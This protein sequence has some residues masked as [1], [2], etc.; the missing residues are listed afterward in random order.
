MGSI[1]NTHLDVSWWVSWSAAT[2][3]ESR[4]T[5]QNYANSKHH[6]YIIKFGK[7]IQKIESITN[8]MQVREQIQ[9]TSM[10]YNWEVYHHCQVHQVFSTNIPACHGLRFLLQLAHHVNGDARNPKTLQLGWFLDLTANKLQSANMM[11]I[12][13]TAYLLH[14]LSKRLKIS[15]KNTRLDGWKGFSSKHCHC[16]EGKP[17]RLSHSTASGPSQV[18][19][20]AKM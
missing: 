5:C 19:V 13:L 9:T 3:I 8:C 11:F 16:H 2:W 15:K 20:H 7:E 18:A 14:F 10:S 1:C 4:R 17:W 6:K 12:F